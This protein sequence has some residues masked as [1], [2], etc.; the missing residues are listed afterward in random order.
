MNSAS[1][2][3]NFAWIE[4]GD[5]TGALSPAS[6]GNAESAI[7]DASNSDDDHKS[8]AGILSESLSYTTPPTMTPDF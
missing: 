5:H 3:R 2:I 8:C 6:Q 4:E 1:R 7:D